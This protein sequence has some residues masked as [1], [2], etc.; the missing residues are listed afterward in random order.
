MSVSRENTGTALSARLCRS[1][2]GS[3]SPA[4]LKRYAPFVIS[5]RPVQIPCKKLEETGRKENRRESRLKRPDCSA[6]SASAPKSI[7]YPPIWRIVAMESD[8]EEDSASIGETGA[9][10][11]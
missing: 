1:R 3:A 6:A 8:T 4:A 11:G 10:E 2:T 9:A 7:I 5:S